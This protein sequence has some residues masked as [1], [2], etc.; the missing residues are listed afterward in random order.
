MAED[1][2][3]I[4]IDINMRQNV[5]EES[6][7]ASKGMDDMALASKSLQDSLTQQTIY[8]NKLQKEYTKAKTTFDSLNKSSSDP[9]FLKRRMEA[10]KLFKE[11]K[12]ELEDEKKGLEELRSQYSKMLKEQ[13][14]VNNSRNTAITRMRKVREEMI[15]LQMEGKAEGERYRELE[16]ELEQLGTAYRVVNQEQKSLTTG[17]STISGIVSGLTGIAGAA[18]AAQG[19]ISLFVDDNERLAKIQTKLQA[20]M[21]ITIGLQQVSNTL[22]QTSSFRINFVNKATQLYTG[23]VNRLSAA[24]GISNVAA[25]ALMTTL[26]VGLSLAV[27]GIIFLLDKYNKKQEETK[28]RAEEMRQAE[29]A[30]RKE[31]SSGYGKEK[32]KI[33]ALRTTLDSEN[34]S[35]E[36]KYRAIAELKKII[37]GYLAEL[38]NEGRVIRENTKAIDNY[39]V[40]LEKSLKMKA[41]ENRLAEIYS[42]QFNLQMEFSDEIVLFEEWAKRMEHES[43]EE[44]KRRQDALK[45]MPSGVRTNYHTYKQR[46][47]RLQKEEEEIQK[48]MKKSGLFPDLAPEKSGS[49]GKTDP[50]LKAQEEL[51]KKTQDYQNRIDAAMVASIG[52]GAE[53]QREAAR[54][55]YEKTKRLIEEELRDLDR[56]EGI[57]GKPAT[58]QRGLLADYESASLERYNNKIAEINQTA[59]QQ[60]AEI[61]SSVDKRFQ[62]QLDRDISDINSYYDNLIAKAKEAGAEQ[63]MLEELERTHILETEQARINAQLRAL[64]FETDITLRRMAIS[65]KFYL[66]ESDKIKEALQQEKKAAHDRLDLLKKQY[67][68]APTKELEEDIEAATVAIEEMDDAI[69]KL[70]TSK[71]QEVADYV[72]QIASGLSSLLGEDSSAGKVLGWTAELADSAKSIAEGIASGNPMAIADGVLNAASTIK[73]I[74]QTNRQAEK[75]IKEYARELEVIAT[76]YAI[77]VITAI[78]DI[79]GDADSLFGTD[80][81]NSLSRGMEG[82][83]AAVQKEK[84]LVLELG[85]TTVKVGK[86]KK[87]FLGI[88][89]GTKDIWESVL[90]GYKKILDTDEELI[91]AS[92]QLNRE[93]A[94]ALLNSGK[95]SKETEDL[96]TNILAAQDAAIEAMQQVEDTLS[97]I[98]GNIGNDLREALVEAF[99]NGD[100]TAAADSF[101]KSASRILENWI[102]QTLF[103]SVF[104]DMLS[105]LEGKMKDSFGSGGDQD[106]T[107]D[108]AWFMQNYQSGVDEYMKGLEEWKKQLKD[109]YDIDVFGDGDREGTSAGLDRITQ[110]SANELN[111][112]F[113]ALRQQVGEIRNLQKE[114]ALVRKSIRDHLARIEEN[115]E[116]C[117]LLEDVKNSLEDIQNRGLKVKV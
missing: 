94:E 115:T 32:A 54:A 77:T 8:V 112:N 76:R 31:I 87:K 17:G 91:D 45:N 85:D 4:D 78:K 39:L 49:S 72:S 93:I 81:V 89:T 70:S 58:E 83:S 53:K 25:K 22:H 57:T 60:I 95:L 44:Y 101:G 100:V 29:E 56:L 110:D 48:Q 75:E 86:K 111:G 116:Y 117:R 43:D 66:F 5:S 46:M 107:D 13:D 80:I 71:F 21:A 64:E 98:A 82:F 10:S 97:N 24:L 74:F 1:L 104:G 28:K 37:P 19:I 113:Y 92:G 12:A 20:A 105:Q 35:R 51:L 84:D 63:G 15:G 90:T 68:K 42:K 52:K 33:E 114:A 61:F 55:E 41:A 34:V 27:T 14:K 30:Y 38:D 11:V 18:S 40:S 47:K 103:S 2:K 109:L 73:D 36:K 50:R 108:I 3:P 96:I 16:R 106:I 9:E 23:T 7:K 69:K 59:E 102:S 99:R 26:T 62:S 88:T 6:S 67:E 79:T 65:G